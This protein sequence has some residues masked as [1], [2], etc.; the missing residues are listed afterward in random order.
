MEEKI[1]T[2]KYIRKP[3][4]VD[5][6]QVTVENFEALAAWC[7]GTITNNDGTGEPEEIDPNTQHIRVRVHNPRSGRQTKAF[8][9]DWILYTEMGYKI[10]NTRA[11][12]GS[13]EP[14]KPS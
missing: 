14:Y 9:G 6:V 8:V 11:F 2:T 7:Q 5:A 10:Y 3:L 12:I 4:I 1:V 13:F